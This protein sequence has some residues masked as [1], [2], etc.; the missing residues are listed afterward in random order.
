MFQLMRNIHLGLGLVF[1]LMAL[2]FAVS[3]VVII[4]R[5]W[6]QTKP[7]ETE[8]PV[9]ISAEAKGTPRDAAMELMSEHGLAGEL[10]QVQEEGDKVNLRIA[11]PGEMAE[12][13]YSRSSGE[14]VIKLRRQGA[15]ETMV[16][17]HTNHGL[18]HDH[19]PTQAWAIINFLASFGLLLLGASG[20]YLWFSHHKE[21][22]IGGV[23]LAFSLLFGLVTLTLTRLEG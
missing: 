3:S 14:G 16:Q 4:Y 11:L 23:L 10:R 18:W 6:I 9:T 5:P 17:L 19:F 2:V 12:V 22:V 13:A 8:R 21:R 15:L 1:V 7:T 20:I